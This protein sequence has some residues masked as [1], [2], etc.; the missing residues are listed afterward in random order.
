[1]AKKTGFR[2]VGHINGLNC[3]QT[4]RFLKTVGSDD[5]LVYVGD[6]VRVSAGQAHRLLPAQV[7]AGVDGS[8]GTLGVVARVLVNEEGRPRVHGLS[9]SPAQ[10]PNISLTADADFLDVYMDPGIIYEIGMDGSAGRSQIGRT[11]G[12]AA[13]ARVTAAGISGV[14][15]DASLSASSFLPIRV[16]GISNSELGTRAGSMDGNVL[17]VLNHA[18]LNVT[19]SY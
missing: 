17:C 7:T 13:T 8:F 18:V 6:L 5:S 14:I 10:H 2:P 16:I 3:W 15:L 11:V 19:R 4:Q 12:I 1:M 9:Q